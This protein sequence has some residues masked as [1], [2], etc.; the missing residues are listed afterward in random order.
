MTTTAPGLQDLADHKELAELLA[1]QGWWLD[2]QHFEEVGTVFTAD[3]VVKTQSGRSEGLEAL[4]AQA[5]RVH[6][7]FARTQHLTT[8]VLIEVDGDRA[9]VRAN[10]VAV[11]VRDAAAAE[12]TAVLGEFYRFE[13]VRTPAGWRF[14]SLEV[15]PVWRSG[16]I[17]RQL[18]AG[19][20]N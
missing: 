12:P 19:K 3:A 20:S 15:T 9:T 18:A 13:A 1:R 16:D 14:S 2:E 11:F 5:R 6:S 8:G 17:S 4:A 7:D 10:L